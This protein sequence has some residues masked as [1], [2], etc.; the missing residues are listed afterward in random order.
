MGDLSVSYSDFR[1]GWTGPGNIDADPM[2]RDVEAGDYRLS[3][4]SPCIDTGTS[5]DLHVD[6]N[7][8]PRPLEKLGVGRDDLCGT[9]DMGAYEYVVGVLPTCTPLPSPLPTSTVTP[10]A[11]FT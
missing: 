4:Y 2:F 11:T 6:L 10:M 3:S 9:Y 5:V 1:G 7:G 8:N